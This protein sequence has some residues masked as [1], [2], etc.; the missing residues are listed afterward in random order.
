VVRVTGYDIG[1]PILQDVAQLPK[2]NVQATTE[3]R[4][5]PYAESS[6]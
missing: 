5:E 6:R 1:V 3:Y 2:A 4:L